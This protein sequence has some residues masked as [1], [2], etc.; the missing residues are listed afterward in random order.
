VLIDIID[1]GIGIPKTDLPYIFDR[2][3]R[4]DKSR[5]RAIE[6]SGLGLS[7]ARWIVQS[8]SGTIRVVSKE[9]VGTHVFVNLPLKS[10]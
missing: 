7:I 3:Y 8:H 5:N 10:K 4:G 2:Y 6:G 9:G 1:T